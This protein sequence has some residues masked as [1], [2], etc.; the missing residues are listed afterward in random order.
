MKLDEMKLA[1]MKQH[2]EKVAE[3]HMWSDDTDFTPYECS[4]GNYD[5]AYYGGTSDG[6]AGLARF[7]LRKFFS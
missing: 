1:A 6:E 3:R 4:G 7:L 5:D 2:L